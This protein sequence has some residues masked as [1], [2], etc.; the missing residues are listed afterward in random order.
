MPSRAAM[1]IAGAAPPALHRRE[2]A[3]QDVDLVL[4]GHGAVEEAPQAGH[5][6]PL[7]GA[8]AEIDLVDHLLEVRVEALHL[9]GARERDAAA[10]A[11]DGAA[12]RVASRIS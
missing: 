4:V 6:V 10:L 9:D 5:Q 8:V 7:A 2:D 3:A 11:V 1:R 12:A